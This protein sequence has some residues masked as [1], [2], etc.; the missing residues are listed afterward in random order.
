LGW[1]VDEETRQWLTGK[2]LPVVYWHYQFHKTKNSGQRK[3]YREAW[4]R[5]V[6]DFNADLFRLGLTKGLSENNLYSSIAANSLPRG[7]I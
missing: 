1:S 6:K 4:Q 5:A 2:L 3:R 7:L